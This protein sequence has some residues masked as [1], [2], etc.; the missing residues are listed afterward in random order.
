MLKI[1]LLQVSGVVPDKE[2]HTYQR[3]HHFDFISGKLINFRISLEARGKF[4]PDSL[5]RQKDS[6]TPSYP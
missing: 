4:R 1:Y 3:Q 6:S 2:S 5:S